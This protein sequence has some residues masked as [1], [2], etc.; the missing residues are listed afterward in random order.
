[1]TKKSVS[2]SQSTGA[3]E[4]RK[5]D[6]RVLPGKYSFKHPLKLKPL[7]WVEDEDEDGN[8][9]V[10]G[11][12]LEDSEGVAAAYFNL[13]GNQTLDEITVYAQAWTE[14][15]LQAREHLGVGV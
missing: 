10:K 4:F 12:V 2:P 5:P 7:R 8:A 1:M 6:V 11:M 14:G 3:P 13:V 9:P 15:Y